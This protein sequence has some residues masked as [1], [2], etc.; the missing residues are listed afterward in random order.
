MVPTC[1]WEAT[2]T[3]MYASF[4]LVGKKSMRAWVSLHMPSMVEA[5]LLVGVPVLFASNVRPLMSPSNVSL[6]QGSNAKHTLSP[7]STLFC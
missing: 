4:F 3:Y 5:V 6:T 1:S 7:V 2:T